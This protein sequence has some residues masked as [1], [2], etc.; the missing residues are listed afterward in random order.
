M[1]KDKTAILKERAHRLSALQV[2]MDLAR[3]STV[4][5]IE[6]TMGG[7]SYA[8]ELKY[9]RE[10]Y[11][12]KDYTPLPC[13]PTFIMGLINIRRKVLSL[14]DLSPFFDLP[15]AEQVEG[16]YA[17]VLE[18]GDM[19]FAILTEGIS[20]VCSIKSTDIQPA[21]PSF[22][23]VRQ[24]FLKGITSEGIAILDAIKLLD[25]QPLIVNEEL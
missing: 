19:E 10:V 25:F 3:V 22:T 23:K 8:L 16:R 12:I 14:I 11:P 5:V 1:A 24:E 13:V 4:D 15:K 18:R 20:K 7:E 9:I 2:D 6:F 21:L 17:I